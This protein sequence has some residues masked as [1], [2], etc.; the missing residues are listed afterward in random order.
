MTDKLILDI[1][2]EDYCNDADIYRWRVQY[3]VAD[4]PCILHKIFETW[5]EANEFAMNY[6]YND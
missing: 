3:Q 6:G 2:Q 1:F 5:T 4:S